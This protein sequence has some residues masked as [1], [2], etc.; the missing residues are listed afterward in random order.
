VVLPEGDNR[1]TVYLLP[2]TTSPTIVPL[3]GSHRLDMADGRI[4]ASRG[5][6]RS[7]IQLSRAPSTRG[8]KV[9]GMMVTHLLDP[10]PTEVHVYWS[11]WARTPMFVATP[12]DEV[13]QIEEGRIRRADL[14]A[15]APASGS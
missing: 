6:T 1:W 15:D 4:T 3:G 8:A 13:W 12:N 7:C 5:F 2:G 9:V 11:L 14:D 10:T